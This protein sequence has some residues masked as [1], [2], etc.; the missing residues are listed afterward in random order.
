MVTVTVLASAQGSSV[1]EM[2]VVWCAARTME[3][4]FLV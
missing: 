2:V 3:S 1:V 4:T